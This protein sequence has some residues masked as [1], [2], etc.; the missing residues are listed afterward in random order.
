MMNHG[1]KYSDRIT[2]QTAWKTVLQYCVKRYSYSSESK[3]AS[4]IRSGEVRLSDRF[5]DASDI[6]KTNQMLV[7][8]RLPWEESEVLRASDDCK[9]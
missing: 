8:R 2:K 4:R 5:C 3:W 1:W 7:Y 9:G 6:L